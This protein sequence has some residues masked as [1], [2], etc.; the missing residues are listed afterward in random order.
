MQ[1]TGRRAVTITSY[2]HYLLES[3]YSYN[4]HQRMQVDD[5]D[6]YSYEPSVASTASSSQASIWSA[7]SVS[8]SIASSISDDFRSSQDDAARDKAYA[9]AQISQLPSQPQCWPIWEEASTESCGERSSTYADVTS[10]PSE[11]R[12]NPRRSSLSRNQKPPTLQRQ[13]ERK[14]NFVDNLVGKHHSNS[15]H[16]RVAEHGLRSDVC[17]KSLQRKW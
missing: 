10:V 12:Q 8:S 7:R 11:Q 9:Q 2:G 6:G 14:V 16:F 1:N 4:Y 5:V 17:I 15:F 3:H 13:C